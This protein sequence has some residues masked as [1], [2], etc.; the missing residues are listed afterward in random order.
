MEYQDLISLGSKEWAKA[1]AKVKSNLQE[2]A[3]DLIELYAKREKAKGF[4]F[5]KDT[6]WQ[7]EFEENFPYMKQMTN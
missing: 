7:K 4:M 2:I 6:E 5:S 3:K 1:K